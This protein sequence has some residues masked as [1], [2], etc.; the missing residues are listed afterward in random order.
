MKTNYLSQ[1][2]I[3][4][5][6]KIY[7]IVFIIVAAGHIAVESY[8]TKN[9]IVS[10]I[11][12]KFE[13]FKLPLTQSLLDNNYKITNNI[14]SEVLA[15]P[16]LTGAEVRDA[17]GNIVYQKLNLDNSH[18]QISKELNH[19]SAGQEIFVGKINLYSS[20]SLVY[21]KLKVG[22]MILII[23]AIVQTAL[24]VVLFVFS[25]NK[26]VKKPLYDLIENI[27]RLELDIKNS[28]SIIP[29]YN[30]SFEI[31]TLK[32][33]FNLM[34]NRVVN[35]Q[36]QLEAL[37]ATLEDKVNERTEMY[38]LI[39][40]KLL[41]AQKELHLKVI[42]DDMTGLYNRRYFNETFPKMINSAKRSSDNLT[43]VI[44]D[45]D[46]FKQYN[47]TYGHQAGDL[48]LKDVADAVSTS[49]NRAD[50][51]VF[52]LGG[53]EFGILFRGIE[54]NNAVEY[55]DNIR[56]RIEN[57]QIEHKNNAA[58]PF[59][60]CSF[61]MLTVKTGTNNM[62]SEEIYKKTDQLL[63]EAKNNGRN[64]LKSEII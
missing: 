17:N 56:K 20:Y 41:Q 35:K 36:N 38:E 2:L 48:A 49:M 10:K 47:D 57:L 4:R 62:T 52:R 5:V 3:A 60:T 44:F 43:L 1:L 15:H 8:F 12:L 30:D 42:K 64:V 58:S 21:D 13:S 19:I 51:Y 22:W 59:L 61:G 33:A 53:E 14:V 63:Y 23:D 26:L 55:I 45:I 29:N 9:D 34:I 24:L 46:C 50:D 18:F 7:I 31:H 11:E 40:D 28:A 32:T 39:N 54:H 16:A 27:D 25:L 37:N 6:L